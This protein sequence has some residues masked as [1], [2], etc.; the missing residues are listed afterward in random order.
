MKEISKLGSSV[1][2]ILLLACPAASQAPTETAKSVGDRCAAAHS[3]GPDRMACEARQYASLKRMMP[4]L[5]FIE[6]GKYVMQTL[7]L[8]QCMER[9]S[10]RH[11]QDYV[12]L[13]ECYDRSISDTCGGREACIS[14]GSI[15][16]IELHIRNGTRP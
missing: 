11:G 6:S 14:N 5:E 12:A 2:L 4:I 8:G 13:A 10:D 1:A 15:S 7:A 3:E 16:G 9:T